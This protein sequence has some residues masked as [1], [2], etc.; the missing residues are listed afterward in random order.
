VKYDSNGDLIFVL[1]GNGAGGTSVAVD[2]SGD[3][4]LTGEVINPV[5]VTD[6]SAAKIHPSGAQVWVTPISATGKIVSDSAGNVFV[7]GA[8]N[9]SYLITKLAPKGTKV[10]ESR[11]VPGQ[12]VTDAVVDPF[13]NLLVTGTGVNAIFE[14]DIF[15]LRI[16]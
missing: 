12:D 5:N 2:P 14:D 1:S 11:F 9:S 16:K 7:A 13:D 10:F 4:L 8:D 15:T 6:I 3:I